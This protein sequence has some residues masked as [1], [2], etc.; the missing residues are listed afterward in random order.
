[1]KQFAVWMAA[2][3]MIFS[4]TACGNKPVSTAPV[5]E[6]PVESGAPSQVLDPTDGDVT[7]SA[8]PTNGGTET[9][10]AT[11]SEVLDAILTAK[12]GTGYLA[13]E[14][15]NTLLLAETADQTKAAV[16]SVNGTEKTLLFG[17]CTQKEDGTVTVT[18]DTTG[19]A[20]TAVI[21]QE[22]SG[23]VVI[24][25]ED[26]TKLTAKSLT[27]ENIGETLKELAADFVR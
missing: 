11:G 20:F 6:P 3:M 8:A 1:M 17:T 23:N 10:A 25:M 7:A 9:G 22:E 14:D 4:L 24:S 19:E 12:L 13:Q 15:G 27:A 2:G 16:L 26:G 18:D 21:S 5:S